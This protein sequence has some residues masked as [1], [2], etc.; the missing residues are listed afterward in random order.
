MIAPFVTTYHGWVSR[1]STTTDARIR[2]AHAIAGGW[3]GDNDRDAKAARALRKEVLANAPASLK[4]KLE[5]HGLDRTPRISTPARLERIARDLAS[6]PAVDGEVLIQAFIDAGATGVT[7]A[8]AIPERAAG[9]MRSRTKK[10]ELDLKMLDL[11]EL[12][13]SIASATGV[14]RI[15]AS[16][17]RLRAISPAIKSLPKLRTLH[18]AEN[19]MRHVPDVVFELERLEALSLNDND[20]EELPDAIGDLGELR[21]LWLADNPLEALPRGITRLRKLRFLHL[22]GLPWREPPVWLAEMKSL[23]ELWLASHT[24]ARL[25][26]EILTL[27]RLRRLH[28]WYS[29]LES[30]PEELFSCTK[31]EELRIGNNP[32]PDDVMNRLREALPKTTIY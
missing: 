18:L 15:D 1:Q 27:P 23:E 20:I 5:S 22:G 9:V 30:V 3:G 21:D 8:L 14:V 12:P 13:D 25:P 19:G 11:A 29:N 6:D 32:L 10:G 2:L 24:L 16:N 17:N 28:L 26:R 31:L 7:L 4:E